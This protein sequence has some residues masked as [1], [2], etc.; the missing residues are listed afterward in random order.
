MSGMICTNPASP[1]TNVTTPMKMSPAGKMTLGSTVGSDLSVAGAGHKRA[2]RRGA[3][4]SRSKPAENKIKNEAADE[5]APA[6]YIGSE[7]GPSATY[8]MPLEN[9]ARPRTSTKIPTILNPISYSFR[10]LIAP[11]SM[12]NVMRCKRL[13]EERAYDVR[14]GPCNSRLDACVN[15]REQQAHE[16]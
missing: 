1:E 9:A 6:E 5:N 13:Q 8:I 7:P 2:A 16:F 4:I 12:S 14:R 3:S 11:L 15:P 10:S